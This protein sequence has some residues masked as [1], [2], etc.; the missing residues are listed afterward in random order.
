MLPS[1]HAP[2]L[3]DRCPSRGD[4]Y[5]EQSRVSG[6]GRSSHETARDHACKR[7][8]RI[9]MQLE[10]WCASLGQPAERTYQVSSCISM[11]EAR[12]IWKQE[13]ILSGFMIAVPLSAHPLIW[14]CLRCIRTRPTMWRPRLTCCMQLSA[15]SFSPAISSLAS[16]CSLAL[17]SPDSLSLHSLPY[18]LLSLSLSPSLSPRRQM[19]SFANTGDG[20]VRASRHRGGGL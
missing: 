3:H 17:L 13:L 16:L 1:L 20:L 15:L 7:A 14:V 8:F 4:S 10:T 5:L 6:E 18:P 11:R 19:H 9:E 2:H 12:C